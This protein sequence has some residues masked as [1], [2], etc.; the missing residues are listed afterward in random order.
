MKA[1]FLDTHLVVW[2]FAGLD[3]KLPVIVKVL[4]ESNELYICP[5][6]ILE[7]Q[8]LYEIK[9]LNYPSQDIIA[10]LQGKIGLKI[11]DLALEI[12]ARKATELTWTRDPFDR[13][14]AAN[15]ISRSYPL[16]TKDQNILSNL[17]FA[18]WDTPK[19]LA[20]IAV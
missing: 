8:Y 11:D 16:I 20:H 12:I 7:L 9:R 17:P 10:D 5:I 2:L 6:V 3:E 18:I 13:L 4:I 14:I 19:P 1:V 15:A